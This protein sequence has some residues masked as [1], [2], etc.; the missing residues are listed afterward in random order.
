[1]SENVVKGSIDPCPVG[2][3]VAPT[4]GPDDVVVIDGLVKDYGAIH[5]VRGISFSVRR[6]EIASV[7]LVA[8]VLGGF[9][10][11]EVRSA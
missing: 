8:A 5:A 6:D 4:T 11:R 9:A 3:P 10:R 2:G 7:A 1:M